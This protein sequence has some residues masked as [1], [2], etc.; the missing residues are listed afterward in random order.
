MKKV[1]PLSGKDTE[2]L[3]EIKNGEVKS[4]WGTTPYKFQSAVFADVLDNY[5]IDENKWYPLGASFDKPIKGGLGEYLRDNHNLN[6]RYA[7]LI[8]PIMQKE[9]YIYSKGFKPV[10]IKKK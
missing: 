1:K 4:T 7:S 6:P 10:L 8:G 9:N 3:Y 5:L 2:I